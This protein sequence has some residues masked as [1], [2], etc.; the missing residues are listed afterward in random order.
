MRV[1]LS[2][3][4]ACVLVLI[5]GES[6]AQTIITSTSARPVAIYGGHEIHVQ[7]VNRFRFDFDSTTASAPIGAATLPS[8]LAP[9]ASSAGATPKTL[10]G[11]PP[12]PTPVTAG[13]YQ[14]GYL[15][16]PP[17]PPPPARYVS[18]PYPEACVQTD[19]D[20]PW[21]ASDADRSERIRVCWNG[22]RDEVD[23]QR[24]ALSTLRV[25]INSA[26][27]AVGAEQR[28]YA[29][30]L[31]RFRQPLLSEADANSLVAFANANSTP[32]T[33]PGCRSNYNPD[34]DLDTADKIGQKLG[35]LQGKLADLSTAPGYNTWLGA[36]TGPV[37]ASN[38]ALVKLDND[39]LAEATSY[40]TGTAATGANSYIAQTHADFLTAVSANQQWRDRL[41]AIPNL[42]SL[43]LVVPINKCR[44]WYGKGRTDTIQLTVTDLSPGAPATPSLPLATNTCNPT[45]IAS[46]GVGVT[47]LHSPAYA[48]VPNGAGT[49]V[50][51]ESAVNHRSPLYAAFYNVTPF[52]HAHGSRE[53]FLSPGIG[54]TSTS[55]ASVADFLIGFSSSFARRLLFVT[56]AADFGKRDQLVPG[57]YVGTPQ[58]ALT[59][60]PTQSTWKIG[61]IVTISF[62]VAPSS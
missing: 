43:Q 33:A 1:R 7:Y 58:G 31:Q 8:Q 5:A 25:A 21:P 42:A 61:A 16:P 19:V 11:A 39:L 6:L 35:E 45:S 44:E 46:T 38:A 24:A 22:I 32:G 12:P 57:V 13:H 54:L 18:P 20:Q 41:A 51:G 37:A 3:F 10:P 29:L 17:P 23:G 15:P 40:S 55:S 14:P 60:V 49:Q 4:A 47:F 30:K 59:S 36:A 50:V 26:I 62:G 48:F 28:C 52:S 56:G 27:R 9:A 34:W 53:W 2:V